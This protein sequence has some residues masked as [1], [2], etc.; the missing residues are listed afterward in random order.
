MWEPKLR[1]VVLRSGCALESPEV[2]SPGRG[3]TPEQ[4]R[5]GAGRR[6]SF[7][8]GIFEKQLLWLYC[9]AKVKNH[10]F[11]AVFLKLELVCSRIMCR[12]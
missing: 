11:K 5:V 2:K 9:A 1:A 3:A 12:A 4:F 7:G 6:N 8:I 10:W